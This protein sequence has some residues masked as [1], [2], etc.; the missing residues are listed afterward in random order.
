M[1]KAKL[2]VTKKIEAKKVEKKETKRISV[3]KQKETKRSS[4]TKKVQQYY[5]TQ[6][7]F[8]NTNSLEF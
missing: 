3:T 5:Y 1:K 6:T 7:I 4:V 2:S 8:L